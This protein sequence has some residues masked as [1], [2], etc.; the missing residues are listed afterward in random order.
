M[1]S[2]VRWERRNQNI[3]TRTRVSHVVCLHKTV[4]PSEIFTTSIFLFSGRVGDEKRHHIV[5]GTYLWFRH[6]VYLYYIHTVLLCI[7]YLSNKIYI[8]LRRRR[9]C[10]NVRYLPIV[11]CIHN[12]CSHRRRCYCDVSAARSVFSVVF[13]LH[14][15]VLKPNIRCDP[16]RD[17]P[18][19]RQVGWGGG[20]EKKEHTHA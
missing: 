3:C 5:V 20:I 4:W 16:Q 10:C 1:S 11:Y 9:C 7:A 12:D 15:F 8:V 19:L 2:S 14:Q 18:G 17:N 6:C 13:A